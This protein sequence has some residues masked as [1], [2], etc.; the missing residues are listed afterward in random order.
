MFWFNAFLS[1]RYSSC[2]GYPVSYLPLL[3]PQTYCVTFRV[4]MVTETS[5]SV[6]KQVEAWSELHEICMYLYLETFYTA[7]EQFEIKKKKNVMYHKI[8]LFIF[9]AYFRLKIFH[10]YIKRLEIC[11]LDP[12]LLIVLEKWRCFRFSYVI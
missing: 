8:Q 11:L 10:N 5:L 12:K 4:R 3:T 9:I 2:H 1:P 6:W 7:M